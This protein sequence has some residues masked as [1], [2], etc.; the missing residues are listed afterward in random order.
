MKVYSRV[1]PG[2]VV[3]L[4]ATGSILSGI[5]VSITGKVVD[6]NGPVSG[7][8][9][10]VR[11][12]ENTT[13]TDIE[14]NF[15]LSGLKENEEIEV[16]AWKY[17]YYI[18]FVL[19]TPPAEDISLTLRPYHTE[20]NPD[21]EWASPV[22]TNSPGSCINCHP[23]I[24]GEWQKNAHGQAIS[25]PRFFSMYNGTDIDGNSVGS[26]YLTDFP[27][28][29]GNCSSCHAPGAAVD[30]Y[31]NSDMNEIRDQVTAGIHCDYC[32]KVG[33][34]YLNPATRSVYHN[35]PG[36]QSQKV[37]RPPEGD[38]IF[39]GPYPDIH[40][41]DT[42]LPEISESGFCAPCHQFSMWG[43]PIY[44]SYDEWLASP[45]QQRGVTCQDCH[46]P[47]NGAEFFALPS[48]GGV[49]HPPE[50]IPSHLQLG[51]RDVDLLE[52]TITLDMEVS[53][54]E[55][56][57]IVTVKIRN[58]GAGH[59]VPTDYPGRQIIL[60]VSAVDGS[61]SI[62]DQLSG[63]EIANWGG[64][65]KGLPGIIYAKLLRDVQTGQFPVVTYWKQTLIQSDNRIPALQ[66]D[67]TSYGFRLPSNSDSA[68]VTASVYFRRVCQ[69]V[70]EER[71][72]GIPDIL[73]E[74]AVE[75]VEFQ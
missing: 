57:I 3:I 27:D 23:M 10:K 25:N 41:P 33:G 2:L 15:T 38:D 54:K 60:V 49:R 69:K 12:I 50:T 63:P 30:G 42:Y 73:M 5:S 44:E 67:V 37:L 46:M 47:P 34:Y 13:I 61:G 9:V 17:G 24:I 65:Y 26:G 28:T 71:N 6:S 11:A 16:T 1:I 48:V 75:Q 55:D 32:H 70:D 19:V 7:A 72:W 35:V 53:A 8:L 62:L 29:A 40:D 45:Y 14:G 52:S 18:A 21:Y 58:T 68:I 64:S 36:V 56:E 43:T 74:K 22:D 20:D 59:H 31:L 51:A 39:F 4:L 66:Q